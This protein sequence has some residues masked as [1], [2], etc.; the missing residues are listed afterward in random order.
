MFCF[1]FVGL[2]DL[3][4][5]PR[6]NKT[7]QN[8]DLFALGDAGSQ[9]VAPGTVCNRKEPAQ[10]VTGGEKRAGGSEDHQS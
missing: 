10:N 3:R 7:E 9:A 6:K 5:A 4:A 1:Q 8:S 2:Q